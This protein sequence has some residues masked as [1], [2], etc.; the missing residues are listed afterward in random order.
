VGKAVTCKT[1]T[2]YDKNDAAMIAKYGAKA[3]NGVFI[4]DNATIEDISG[5][6]TRVDAYKIKS[7]S[8][9]YAIDASQRP[10]APNLELNPTKFTRLQGLPGK[11]TPLYV[12]DGQ[13]IKEV[14]LSSISPESIAEINVLKNAN[15]ISKYG[16]EAVNGVIEINTKKGYTEQ[17]IIRSE[18]GNILYVGAENKLSVLSNIAARGNITLKISEGSVRFANGHY[19]AKVTRPGKIVLSVYSNGELVDD[20]VFEVKPKSAMGTKGAV[21]EIK[22]QQAKD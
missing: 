2:V 11:E 6:A 12:I 19:I 20:V 18:N 3:A 22:I 14:Q 9:Y 16:Q 1:A 15:A 4:A 17:A 5:T 7:D 13:V 21:S 10:N 8:A